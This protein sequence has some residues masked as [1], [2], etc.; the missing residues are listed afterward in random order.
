LRRRVQSTAP[1]LLIAEAIE[2]LKLRAI[3]VARSADQASRALANM[4]AILERAGV[5]GVR[6]FRQFARDLDADWSR[7]ASHT[8][9][10]VDA[11]GQAI[12]IVT[13]HS[14][15]GLEWSVV[16]P[17]NTA[18]GPRP[19]EQFVHRRSD[20][21]LHWVLRDIVPPSLAEAMITE[22][23]EESQ[24]R[25]RLLYVACTRAMDLLVLPDL[26]WTDDAAWMRAIDFKL[27]DVPE[28]DI[29]RLVKKPYE[30]PAE[31]P[32]MQTPEVF[33]A[34]QSRINKA[35]LD[36]RWIRPSDGD[37]DLVQF[38]AAPAVAWEQPIE[39]TSPVR[40][41]SLRGIILH[42]LMEDF[43]TGELEESAEA[44]ERRS[45]RLVRELVP[46]DAPMPQLDVQELSATALRTIALK[47]L[48]DDRDNVIA[49]VPVYGTIGVDIDRL[50]A[51]RADAV[52]YRNGDAEIVFDWK[53]DVDS[54]PDDHATYAHQLAQYVHVLRAKRGA[55]VYMT[56]GEIQWVEPAQVS[57]T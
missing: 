56:T 21:T 38:H 23:E 39:P 47:E 1:S 28:L 5:Y 52:R 42:K 11:E 8:E 16:I 17:I 12:E 45:S 36:I 41:S 29:S 34:E 3:L 20:D 32:N 40:G 49:E 4:D 7:R 15:K 33:E 57:T 9:G 46:A 48:S 50:I 54:K 18:S 26:S 25:L 31:H 22:S 13:I 44:A 43:L 10:V 24:Q 19:P 53:S 27:Q 2:R 14:S 37:P 51:G 35:F 6:G 55:I 30:R